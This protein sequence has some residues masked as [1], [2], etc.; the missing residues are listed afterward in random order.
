MFTRYFAAALMGLALAASSAPAQSNKDLLKS[1]PQLLATLSEVAIKP[2]Y[3][4][5]R[6]KCDGKDVAL[7]AIVKPDGWILTKASELKSAPVCVIKG[8]EKELPAKIVGV[9]KAFDLAILKVEASGLPVVEWRKSSEAEVGAW[10]VSPGLGKEPVAVGVVSVAARDM[11]DEMWHFTPNP[12]SGFMGVVP[13][14]RDKKVVI[15]SVQESSPAGKAGLKDGDVISSIDDED[16]DTA[17]TMLGLLAKT[18][19][20]QEIT[21]KLVRDGKPMEIRLKLGKRPAG[22]NRGDFQNSMGSVLS[23]NRIGYPTILQHDTVLKPA[24]CGGPLVD[25]DGMTIGINIARGGRTESFAI[26]SEVVQTLLPDLMS[27]KLTPVSK[28][29]PSAA[30]SRLKAAQEARATARTALDDAKKLAEDQQK[31]IKDAE[32]RL[33][34]AEDALKKAQADVD[35][36][37][38]KDEPKKDDAK[39]EEPKKDD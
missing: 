27:G 14:N 11:S 30:A 10:V 32:K 13:L 38:K 20:D 9:N 36:E 18:K 5:V 17:R 4:T 24:D 3:S 25:L 22:S 37:K 12:N 28:P 7:G 6:V 1:S 21:V 31:K 39:K 2:S 16:I 29:K 34:D 15:S 26:P 19:P 33:K 35:A 8:G 23:E